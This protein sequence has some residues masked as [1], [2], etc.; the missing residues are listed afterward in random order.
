VCKGA[1]GKGP[2]CSAGRREGATV[3][4]HLIDGAVAPLVASAGP[5][6]ACK[7]RCTASG[8]A[9]CPGASH[10]GRGSRRPPFRCRGR[11]QTGS[12]PTAR[13]TAAVSKTVTGNRRRGQHNSTVGQLGRRDRRVLG[14]SDYP[15]LPTGASDQCNAAKW[16]GMPKNGR[17]P[18]GQASAF[19]AKG[20]NPAPLRRC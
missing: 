20:H 11:P 12:D 4:R 2:R 17:V 9:P 7:T 10:P 13:M 16:C 1:A 6:G 8:R 18:T 5:L 14:A 15:D 3:R 19:R